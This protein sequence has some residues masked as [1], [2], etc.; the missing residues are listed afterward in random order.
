MN[1]A[2]GQ[3][4]ASPTKEFFIDMLTRD[5]TLTQCILDLVDNSI[6]NVIRST[7]LDVTQILTGK[8]RTRSIQHAKIAITLDKTHFRIED[9]CGG[10]SIADA[11]NEVFRFGKPTP[12]RRLKG[13]G[14]Y[15]IG[16]KRALFKIGCKITVQSRTSKE[17]QGFAVDIDVREWT[18]SKEWTFEFTSPLPKRRPNRS[19]RP[20]TKC[21]GK[22]KVYNSHCERC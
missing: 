22:N 13:L 3:I 20:G 11:Q 18:N 7:N 17:K 6:H 16:M 9:T 2:V 19:A 10:I 4:D 15:G 14:V 21:A 1:D 8:A 12:D 5:I